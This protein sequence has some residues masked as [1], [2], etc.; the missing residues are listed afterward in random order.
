MKAIFLFVIGFQVSFHHVSGQGNLHGMQQKI[1]QAFLA[2]FA[3]ENVSELSGI[4][5]RLEKDG[6][7]S[8]RYWQAVCQILRSYFSP[9]NGQPREK[10]GCG[11]RRYRSAGEVEEHE[12]GRLWYK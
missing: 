9:E 10:R 12:F 3:G 6:A 4:T 5:V 8:A 1:E 7:P 2:S 11:Q